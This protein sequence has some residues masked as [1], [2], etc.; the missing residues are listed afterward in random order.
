MII[1]YTSNLSPSVMETQLRESS[2]RDS[3]F[4]IYKEDGFIDFIVEANDDL[5]HITEIYSVKETAKKQIITSNTDRI[6]ATNIVVDSIPYY[7]KIMYVG[8]EINAQEV[9]LNSTVECVLYKGSLYTNQAFVNVEISP[10]LFIYSYPVYTNKIA[11]I[12]YKLKEIELEYS[13]EFGKLYFKPQFTSV[14][15]TAYIN[16]YKVAFNNFYV[17]KNNDLFK[18]IEGDVRY[19]DKVE[20][21]N[22]VGNSLQCKDL[23]HDSRDYMYNEMYNRIYFKEFYYTRT[24]RNILTYTAKLSSHVFNISDLLY[25]KVTK[26]GLEIA[27][28]DTYDFKVTKVLNKD[29]IS[30]TLSESL[31]IPLN[32]LKPNE[33]VISSTDQSEDSKLGLKELVLTSLRKFPSEKYYISQNNVTILQHNNSVLDGTQIAI[34]ELD[35]IEEIGY[36]PTKD[37]YSNYSGCLIDGTTY[38]RVKGDIAT[39]LSNEEDIQLYTEKLEKII[40]G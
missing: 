17:K 2:I 27:D 7:Y 37:I 28:K 9:I 23:V 30:I 1:N 29:K 10:N 14:L 4:F 19:F 40:T 21:I 11:K 18:C 36:T 13:Q 16:N 34:R 39:L 24:T 38:Y 5:D 20:Y 6:I 26:Q 32:T 22:E 25:F 8:E 3:Q 15:Q 33:Y 35:E 12:K 31:N